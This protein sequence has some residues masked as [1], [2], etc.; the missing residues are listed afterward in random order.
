MK[1]K[2]AV[3][4]QK[5]GLRMLWCARRVQAIRVRV[6][7]LEEI[8]DVDAPGSVSLKVECSKKLK[9]AIR[10]TRSLRSVCGRWDPRIAC[11]A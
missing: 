3:L 6:E 2:H 9:T 4:L 5:H 10:Y 11:A 8:L 1:F 7:A